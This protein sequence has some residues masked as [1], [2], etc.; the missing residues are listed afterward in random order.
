M[1]EEFFIVREKHFCENKEI[2]TDKILIEDGNA[3]NAFFARLVND[4]LQKTA[5]A[6]QKVVQS[7]IDSEFT[8]KLYGSRI[9][10]IKTE[11]DLFLYSLR[12]IQHEKC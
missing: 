8:M 10:Y 1:L 7:Y 5:Y 3:A 6:H 11:N 4:R 2:P 12:L 9:G